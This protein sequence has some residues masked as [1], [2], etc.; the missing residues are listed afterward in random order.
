[1][2]G[3]FHSSRR[4]FLKSAVATSV[5]GPLL[6]ARSRADEKRNAANDRIQLGFIGVGTMGGRHHVSGFLNSP[7]VQV[8]ALC[9][10]VRERRD[11][12]QHAVEE[13]YSKSQKGEYKGCKTYGDFRE[14]LDD[15]NVDAVVIATPDHWHS[16]PCV[17]AAEMG[18][19]I[20]CE[21]PLTLRIAEGRKIADAVAEEGVI[22]QTGSQQRS[23][24][25]GRFRKAVELVR[26][27]C[28]GTVIQVRVGVGQPAVPC[29]LPEQP[30][31]DGTDWN[32]WLG[33]CELRGYNEELC[34]KGVHKHFPNWRAYREFAGGG[35]ADFGAHHFDIAQ[36]ALDMD[37]SGPVRIDPPA[38]PKAT[39]GMRF[40]Y[41]NGIVMIHDVFEGER[42]DCLFEGTKGK[43]F[44]S[45]GKL[46]T[47]PADILNQPLPANG[48]RAYPSTNHH[49]NWLNCIRSRQETICPA[50]VGHR[51]ATICHLGNIGYQLRRPLRWDPEK[52]KFLGDTEAN[53][54]L[55]RNMRAPWE[56]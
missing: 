3:A 49:Q 47:E 5:A 50:E 2:S 41:A 1:M 32:M 37:K 36:W 53:A 23:E 22:F 51:S 27:G 30:V 8:V 25:E 39:K 21:K 16:L 42:A 4:A 40:T 54:L 43:I 44:V 38:D 11:F 15:K 7:M 9:D 26:N 12:H 17:Y 19:D 48:F 46:K 45:R 33:P 18:K 6:L 34:P 56:L 24:F 14:L 28:I 13:K 29:K 52:E 31:P 10:V 35:L 55:T 20:Y